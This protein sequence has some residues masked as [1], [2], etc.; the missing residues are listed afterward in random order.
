MTLVLY[1]HPLSADC[2]RVRLLLALLGTPWTQI[3]VDEIPG[4]ET[5]DKRL[6]VLNPRGSL[7]F[8]ADGELVLSQVGAILCH[9]ADTRDPTGRWL[10]Q[11]PKLR[12]LCLE[13]LCFALGDLASADHA[14]NEAVFGRPSP[15]DDPR[16]AARRAFRLLESALAAAHLDGE[17]FL[18]GRQATIADVA[19]FPAVALAADFGCL[20]EAYPKLRGWTRRVRA[21]PGFIAC[22]GIPEFL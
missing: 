19:A 12:A 1:D 21:L 14:R 8:L 4:R 6:R 15:L 3:A 17:G 20:L 7:P 11:A 5:A 10:P 22:P 2:Y 18:A 13:R 9:L 16:S